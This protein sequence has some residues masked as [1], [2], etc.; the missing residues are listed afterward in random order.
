MLLLSC[1]SLARGFDAGPLFQN[2]GFELQAG[3]RVGLVGPNGVG[4]TTL[5]RILAGLDR[6]DD[7][8]VRL[9]AGARVALL[10]QQPEFAPGRSLFD[11]AKTA[12]DELLAAHDDMIHTAER[13][14]KATDEAERKTLAA[15]YDRLHELLSHHDAFHV[16]HR[17]AEVLDGLGFRREDFRRS[18]DIFSGGQQSRLML[19]KL[20]LAAP[21]VMLLDEPSNHLD[22]DTT[23]WLEEYLVKQ[24]EAM[25]IVSHDR[26]FL[27][28]VVTKV[29]ELHASRITS[30]P[31]NFRQYWRLR[32][33]RYEQELRTYEAQR[34]YIEKQ[35][36]YIRR[37]HYGQLHKQA[38]SRQK[39][40]DKIERVERPTLIESPQ[41]HFQPVRRSG[42]VV[43]QVEDLSKSYDRPLFRDLSFNLPRGKRLGIMGPNGSG[44]TT[45]LRVLLGEEPA[46]SGTVQRGHLVEFGYY[47]Q[48]LQTLNPDLP[49]IRAVWPESDPD[50]VEQGMR[51]LL[52][53][54][55]LTG[56]QVYQRVGELSGGEKSRAALAKL[57]AHGVNVLVLDEP[58][59]HL[60]LWACDALEQALLE[61]EGTCIVVSH[62]RYFLNRV[63]DLLL[64]LDG[65]GSVEVIYGNYDTYE[66]MRSQR[67][68][69]GSAAPKKKEPAVRRA[70]SSNNA[71]PARKEKRKRKFPYRKVEEIENDIALAEEELHEL[72]M[73]M[74]SPELYRDGERVKE[75]TS[76]FEAAKERLKQ[77]YEHWE[78]AV[79]LN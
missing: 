72:E 49:V 14:A 37:V 58:T 7:G 52:G 66:L 5:L 21:D 31:G 18:V 68:A 24:P 73:L 47:D 6:P 3:E 15:R 76:A 79:E 51:D 60:D 70:E 23:R 39:Q 74:A 9:H 46:D 11:E 1:S 4:K 22:I 28:R 25:L 36:E 35:E 45:L 71:G 41:M 38:A 26:Y 62:D 77:L 54:F 75:T 63:V 13:L 33:E 48:N 55:G 59:N 16:D 32:Q 34:E 10:R 65:K 78:E 19:A 27:D 43:L 2:I 42:D 57:V 29:F 56:D 30:Y 44:K 8:A 67:E 53:R 69:A 64:V 12:L 40:I 17:I 61:F 20:L 50:T